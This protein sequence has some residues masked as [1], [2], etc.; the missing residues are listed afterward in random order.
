META[1]PTRFVLDG[2]PEVGYFQGGERCPEDT[3]F[4]SCLRAVLEFRGEDYGSTRLTAHNT[5]WRLDHLHT[6]IMG[7]SGCAFRLSW[8]AGW[9]PDNVAIHY[10]SDDPAA[11]FRHALTAVGYDFELVGRQ[12][13][14]TDEAVFR[15][16]IIDSINRGHPLIAHGVIGPPEDCIVAGYDDAGAV[17]VGWNYFQHKP[18]FA[19]EVDFELNGYFRKRHWYDE[20]WSLLLIG[21][22]QTPP[23]LAETYREALRWAL[24]VART[25]AVYGTRHNGFAAYAAWV[26]ALKR[27]HEFATDDLDVLL[28]LHG[29]HDDAVGTVAESR[30]Y[31][32]Q[33]LQQIITH[34]PELTP[35]LAPAAVCY[36]AEH[37]LM[38]KVWELAG[39]LGRTELQARK[40]AD[41]GVR[42]QIIPL[43]QQARMKDIEAAEHLARALAVEQARPV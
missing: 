28:E 19:D 15:A 3:P 18:E 37:D 10:M 36:A 31:A 32:A 14:T 6:F 9:Q 20:T 42:R 23:P 17:L 1:V 22:K 30:W 13:F 25:P 35:H 40:L 43:I 38:W 7:V 5:S 29:V 11:P 41:W 4:P 26:E 2:V 33:F 34:L 39:G 27:D 24:Q 16:K 8:G 12:D 21:E